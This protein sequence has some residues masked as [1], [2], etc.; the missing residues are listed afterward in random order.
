MAW[1]GLNTHAYQVSLPCIALFTSLRSEEVVMGKSLG[2]KFSMVV[3]G[4][5]KYMCTKC[6]LHGLHGLQV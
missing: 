5:L 2:G 6:Q 1:E 4:T 3:M